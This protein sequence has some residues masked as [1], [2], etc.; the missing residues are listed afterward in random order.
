MDWIENH[1]SQRAKFLSQQSFVAEYLEEALDR[2]HQQLYLMTEA[3]GSG[4]SVTEAVEQLYFIDPPSGEEIQVVTD[5]V[6]QH[7][8]EK[9]TQHTKPLA[10]MD[11]FGEHQER[12]TRF[13]Q[14]LVNAL[15]ALHEKERVFSD[16][17]TLE[18]I[19]ECL[20]A[21]QVAYV[22]SGLDQAM[23]QLDKKGRDQRILA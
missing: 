10:E 14:V 15:T 3:D 8:Y 5:T 7:Q 6:L 1:N 13:G 11:D 19:E 9:S 17:Q 2:F 23:E 4:L 12:F 20:Y 21:M 22:S 16:K 18:N